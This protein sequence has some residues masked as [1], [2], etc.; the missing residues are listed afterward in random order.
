MSVKYK[1]AAVPEMEDESFLS[2]LLL[3]QHMVGIYP[4][5]SL[6]RMKA[7]EHNHKAHGCRQQNKRHRVER[8][9]SKEQ[10]CCDF[11]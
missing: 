4:Q 11:R 8:T 1:N 5:S 3:A 2:Q 6:G 7:S 10:T 9:D